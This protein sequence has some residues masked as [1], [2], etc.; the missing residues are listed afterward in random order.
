M[1]IK[2]KLLV[3]IVSLIIA[4]L[5]SIIIFGSIQFTI[6]RMENESLY[7]EA[8]EDAYQQEMIELLKI[9]YPESAV[10]SQIEQ[11]L[12]VENHKQIALKDLEKIKTL[13]RVSSVIEE[14]L[15]AI[16]ELDDLQ[17]DKLENFNEASLNFINKAEEIFSN[18][19]SFRVEEMDSERVRN[20]ESYASFSFYTLQLERASVSLSS[21]LEIT[22]M[23]LRDQKK[24]INDE[25]NRLK[26]LS[27]FITGGLIFISVFAAVIIA[28]RI[29]NSIVKSVHSI[30]SNV[31]HMVHGDLTKEFN[32]LTKDE[33]GAL[34][35][36]M[37]EFQ[38]ELRN[39]ISKMKDLSSRNGVVKDEL[40][41]TTVETSAS[42]EQIAANLKSINGQMKDLDNNISGSST[43]VVEITTLVK[44]LNDHIY[45]QM[46]MV[47]E[48]TASVTEMIASINSVSNLIRRNEDDIKELS[49]AS[50]I[51]VKNITETTS[52]IDDI[53]DSI[54][55]ISGIAGIIQ[56]I[57]SQTNLLAMNAAIEAAHAGINGKGFSVVADEVRKLA[58]ASA[59][60]SSEI[61]KN[62]KG[63]I[64]K[65]ENATVSGEKSNESFTTINSNIENV[66]DALQNISS[67]TSELEV[68]GK[69]ILEAMSSL[70][71]ISSLIKDKSETISS[72]STTVDKNM[73]DVTNISSSVVHAVAEINT[74]FNEVTSAVY[75]LRNISDRVG[76][77]GDDIDTEV[78]KFTTE[79]N[80]SV[81]K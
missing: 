10:I 56:K 30:E 79:D 47:E 15:Q 51:G 29:A 28:L 64:A 23:V 62:I 80:T 20:H 76:E 26:K 39:T 44:N 63:I 37:N 32:E 67:N 52:I 41:T 36:N 2:S 25:V 6:L 59:V 3:L 34:S 60:N 54:N 77:V 58:E 75:G 21:D 65:I 19:Q 5:F 24:T 45:D 9:F 31:S 57:A 43:D 69:Q 16:M 71:S 46:S 33:I 81:P 73:S 22:L 53:N 61:T 38:R 78:N 48:S 49:A 13:I 17:A 14:S 74:G 70:S 18:Q 35:I 27:F 4:L 8:L 66:K 11:Y 55:E 68:G 7:I 50:E 40:I 72:N 12:Q 42:A 1:K